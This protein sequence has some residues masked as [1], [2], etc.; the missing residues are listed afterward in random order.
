M[1]NTTLQPGDMQPTG[2][3]TPEHRNRNSALIWGAIL[4][5]AGLLTF[6]SNLGIFAGVFPFV[7]ALV[8]AAGG[9]AFLYVFLRSTYGNWWAAIP[10]FTLL[11]LAGTVTI[12]EYAPMQMRSLGGAV[13]L[14]GIGLGFLAIYFVRR[15]FWWAL[16]PAGT[17]VSLAATAAVS[18]SG[19]AANDDLSG[20]VFMLGL[21][22]TFLVV[23][24]APGRD[25]RG[26]WWAFIPAA[27]LLLIGVLLFFSATQALA[28]MGYIWGAALVVAGGA[29]L[30]KALGQRPA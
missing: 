8:F 18:E 3:L 28:Y 27:V 20:G 5:G 21:G 17:M 26:R 9:L 29:L 23:A 4:L 22:L 15:D 12:G 24:L 30:Y 25:G 10:A 1:T 11:G 19:L 16:I 6:L 2:G 13:F 7:W 14:G